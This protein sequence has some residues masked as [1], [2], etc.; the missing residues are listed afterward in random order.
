[1]KIVVVVS[2]QQRLIVSV[3]NN[4]RSQGQ[5]NL[6][7]IVKMKIVVVSGQPK[8]AQQSEEPEAVNFDDNSDEY[9]Q[10]EDDNI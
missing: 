10:N 3:L 5:S 1:M 7:T 6:M 9:Y 8:C 4:Q 2:G